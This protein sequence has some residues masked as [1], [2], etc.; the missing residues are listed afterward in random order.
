MNALNDETVARIVG[1]PRTVGCVTTI[2]AGVYEPGHVVRTDPMT[3]HAFSIGELSGL[4]TPR[5]KELVTMLGAIGPSDATQNI[6]G[7][8]WSKLL[9][10]S[11]GNGLAG[12]LGPDASGLTAEQ[13]DLANTIR[14]VTGAE[15]ARVAIAVGVSLEPIRGIPAERFAQAIESVAVAAVKADLVAAS[16]ERNLSPEQSGRLPE[17]GRPSLAQDVLKGR[18]TEVDYLN[19]E[20]VRRGQWAGVDTPLNAAIVALMHRIESG[21]VLPGRKNLERLGPYL[22]L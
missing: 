4:I 3:T 9:W 21:E 7:A 22:G 17:P 1:Y 8:R 18:R 11:M 20:I 6:W 13:A 2:S 16:A 10:N 19:G 5:V 12:M 15:A 14:V